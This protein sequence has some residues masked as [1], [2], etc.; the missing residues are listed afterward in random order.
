MDK[1]YNTQFLCGHDP[2]SNLAPDTQ[3][4]VFPEE[5]TEPQT[6]LETE[7]DTPE[8]PTRTPTTVKPS[9][10]T[11]LSDSLY[12]KIRA[13][14]TITLWPFHKIGSELGI[15]LTTVYTICQQPSTPSRP[16]VGRPRVLTTP[17][18][19]RL[20]QQATLSQENCHKLFRQIAEEIGTH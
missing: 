17:I 14:R 8:P 10:R 13:F 9:L 2:L 20:I 16:R 1:A 19:Q 3:L 12:S 18:R 4:E 5:P 6:N 7:V 15:P 11:E